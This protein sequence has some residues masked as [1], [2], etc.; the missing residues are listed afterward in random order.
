LSAVLDSKG[1]ETG[2]GTVEIVVAMLIAA[3]FGV[4]SIVDADKGV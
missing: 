4:V 1:A 2:V 3:D